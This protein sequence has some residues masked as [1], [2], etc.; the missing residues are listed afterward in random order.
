MCGGGRRDG[1]SGL[2]VSELD[3]NGDEETEEWQREEEEPIVFV[4]LYRV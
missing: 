2:G 1:G 3:T 4:C